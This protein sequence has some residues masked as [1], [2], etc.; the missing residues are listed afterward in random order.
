VPFSSAC[1][2]A[3]GGAQ[4]G[5]TQT[6][7]TV[8]VANGLFTVGLDFGDQFTGDRRWL[9]TAVRCAGESAFTTLNPRQ[10]LAAVPYALGLRPGARV[11]GS[12]DSDAALRVTNNSSASG[13]LGV[14]G[15]SPS[16]VGVWGSGGIRAGVLGT[17]SDLNGSGVEGNASGSN[18]AGVFGLNTTGPGLWGR[19]TAGGSGV[20]GQSS[21]YAV[22]GASTGGFGVYGTSSNGGVVGTGYVGLQGTASGT[23]N[24]QGVRGED[25]S[26][27]SNASAYAGVFVG[28][29]LVA[30]TLSKSAGS[31]RIDHPLD[32]A[33]KYLSHS[34]VESPD[35]KNI[36]D[37]V[38]T[39][40]G[41]G[42]AIVKLPAYF[43]ALNMEF[44]YQ[45]TCIGGYAPVYIAQEIAGNQFKIAGGTPGLK[46]S[47]QVTGTRHD[48]YANQNRI[49]VEEDKPARERG[50]YLY[51][52]GYGQGP[53]QSMSFLQGVS[54]PTG[55]T[56]LDAALHG[57]LPGGR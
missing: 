49:K 3:T 42:E 39:L 14:F 43:E 1:D 38:A 20:F 17:T 7:S 24:S 26:N 47:W 6:L 32:P 16:G 56:T 51:P 48:P 10:A 44:R 4:Q 13:A 53:Q 41:S 9:Q 27:G 37:G 57:E 11:Q 35:M 30:G 46:V 52:S 15:S 54:I 18:A 40:D 12:V 19:G 25:G 55:A 2:A 22:Y 5:S 23:A 36:Y 31:F 8:N 50:H 28:R 29:V 33:N 21:G 34:F 45:L